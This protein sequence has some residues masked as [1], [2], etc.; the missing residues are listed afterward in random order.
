MI[1]PIS[2]SISGRPRPG[3]VGRTMAIIVVGIVLVMLV[4]WFVPAL[5][6]ASQNVLYRLR[7]PI[8]PSTGIVI[9]AI[10]DR[11]LQQIGPWPWRREVM[12]KVLDR[13]TSA[14]PRVIGLDIIYSEGPEHIE[15]ADASGTADTGDLLLAKSISE[16]RHV[17]LP[18]QLYV[19]GS[20]TKG[21]VIEWL[22]PARIFAEGAAATGHVHVA[23]G[24]DG[25]V[26]T[27]QLSKANDN[28][29]RCWAFGLE[30][31][32]LAE[33][34]EYSDIIEL[35]GSL[36]VGSRRI[37][38]R[39][40]ADLTGIPGV[41]LLRPNEM[42]INFAG[43]AGTFR[44]LSI[45]DLLNG[46]L[47]DDIFRDRIVLVGATAPSMGDSRLAPFTHYGNDL[48]QGGR[49]MPGVEI[50][51]N[52]INTIRSG[53]YF[54]PLS[55]P[56]SFLIALLVMGLA[57]I[58][59]HWLDGW[60]QLAILGMLL[61]VVL[62]GSYLAFD[63]LLILPPL[64]P[65]LTGFAIVLPLFL[66]R[67]LAVSRELDD[68]LAALAMSQ[69]GFLP[70][71]STI[72]PELSERAPVLSLSHS[73][74]WKLKA[75]E[76]LT[77]RLLARLS[78]I[79]RVLASMGEGV[80]VTDPDGRIVLV[81][82]ITDQLLDIPTDSLIGKP[83]VETLASLGRID[84]AS[85]K[86]SLAAALNPEE[87][88]GGRGREDGHEVSFS[89]S[90]PDSRHFS[91]LFSALVADAETVGAASAIPDTNESGAQVIGVVILISDIT[92]RVELD[93]V[94]TETFQL[95]SHELRNPLS[96]IQALSEVMLK[97]P[98]SQVKSIE[99]LSSIHDESKRLGET[100]NQ[101]LD[102]ARLESGARPINS[103]MTDPR[104]LIDQ[105]LR[106]YSVA[107]ARKDIRLSTLIDPILPRLSIDAGLITI[108]IGNLIGNAIKYSP[109]HTEVTVSAESDAEWLLISV[110]DQ[111][112]G[113]PES[114]RERIFEKFYRL[115]RDS[116]SETIGSGLG[117]PLVRE[118]LE[119]HG[120]EAW[121]QNQPSGGTVFTI[122]IPLTV[123][124][125]HTRS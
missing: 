92:K 8:D 44:T 101:Y 5:T 18:M 3:G 117:L 30:V 14:S 4:T 74:N 70:E 60:R 62:I 68:K 80:V 103:T 113:I 10:D 56:A 9:L 58:T 46:E 61:V 39:E 65:M 116:D 51:A 15:G 6:L 36:M 87:V 2:R 12:A 38:V 78:F 34:L 21:E 97:F 54:R 73:F 93:R 77:D 63:R 118:I 76:S 48:T 83:I 17:V 122:S 106:Q 26:R 95:V 25:M 82:R 45:V 94:K 66:N 57:A 100:L 23:P 125:R 81:N 27:V 102:L 79:N 121:F 29:E 49:E 7:G 50:H 20:S 109:H 22:R 53:L 40:Q 91:L 72:L 108:A 112:P 105:C 75:V 86:R 67:S 98:V 43:A 55:D 41:T 33:G 99:M 24:V 35:P 69:R 37:S 90:G 16:N 88:S 119:R 31:L 89:I 107:A 114:A 111:G 59:V 64:V 123:H 52:I 11:S 120:G 84:S 124:R 1:N 96:S 13:L 115:E 85:L 28:G 19:A 110:R 47:S 42:Q 104:T 71:R 32:R